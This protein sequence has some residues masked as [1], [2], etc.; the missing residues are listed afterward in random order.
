MVKIIYVHGF[1][2]SPLSF[3]AEATRIWL[4]K[5]RPD[6]HYV[7][8]ALS[9]YPDQALITL[10]KA[11]EGQDPSSI[12]MIGSSLGGFYASYFAE[13]GAIARGVLINPAVSPHK[14]FDSFVG[15]E[16]QSYHGPEK[17]VLEQRHLD[18]LSQCEGE[19][20]QQPERLWVLLQTGD[21]VLEYSMAAQRYNKCRLTIEE[22]GDHSF[23]GYESWLPEIIDFFDL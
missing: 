17:Y 14:R 3:K 16:L 13:R 4:L 10:E 2:S 1:L 5:N 9:S 8:P 12:Y 7:C 22:G 20:I 11:L 18:V 19:H 23:Q 21:E 15:Q 6:I